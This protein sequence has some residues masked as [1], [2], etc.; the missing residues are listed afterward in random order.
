VILDDF[1][2]ASAAETFERFGRGVL[3][4][5]LSELKG[6]ADVATNLI[7]KASQVFTTA[8]DPA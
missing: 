3:G 6:I 7:G 8:A 2:N 1:E 4:S 5:C